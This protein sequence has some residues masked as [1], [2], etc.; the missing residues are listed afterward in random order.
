M[1][2]HISGHRYPCARARRYKI[3]L[4]SYYAF[5]SEPA[6]ASLVETRVL[7][8][9]SVE[10]VKTLILSIFIDIVGA[11]LCYF[12]LRRQVNERGILRNDSARGLAVGQSILK[13]CRN[14]YV[15]TRS[16]FVFAENIACIHYI[17]SVEE[18]AA[19]DVNYLCV[20]I[21]IDHLKV[22]LDL[23]YA[24]LSR[25]PEQAHIALIVSFVEYLGLILSGYLSGEV[26]YLIDD[27]PAE[28]VL[29]SEYGQRYAE[30]AEAGEVKIDVRGAVGVG[31]AEHA[32][33]RISRVYTELAVILTAQTYGREDNIV[34]CFNIQQ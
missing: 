33:N 30:Y 2:R 4:V 5:L 7:E 34:A 25:L 9:N 18:F 14:A 11:I 23:L 6:C 29:R 12:G 17:A 22:I 31:P 10:Y 26:I 16:N 15:H 27:H 21:G 13:V 19:L 20:V 1:L 32:Q 8:L 28:V 3:D 24:E